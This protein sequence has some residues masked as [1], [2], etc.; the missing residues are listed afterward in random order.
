MANSPS[1]IHPAGPANCS[2][3]ALACAGSATT[4]I[5]AGVIA[6]SMAATPNVTCTAKS[7][8]PR[9]DSSRSW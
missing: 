2:H 6:A 9:T 4:V 3:H 7:G 8:L 5:A 1:A